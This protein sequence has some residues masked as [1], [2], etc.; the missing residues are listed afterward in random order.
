MH[1]WAKKLS[2]LKHST[3][4]SLFARDPEKKICFRC[5]AVRAKAHTNSACNGMLRCILHCIPSNSVRLRSCKNL[6]I[7]IPFYAIIIYRKFFTTTSMSFAFTAHAGTRRTGASNKKWERASG[8]Y[9]AKIRIFSSL[10]L[11]TASGEIAF[12]CFKW[13][14]AAKQ[15]QPT[16]MHSVGRIPSIHVALRM[17]IH[18]LMH[19]LCVDGKIVKIPFGLACERRENEWNYFSSLCIGA[20]LALFPSFLLFLFCVFFRFRL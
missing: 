2:Q 17:K 12:Q 10:T 4:H 6:R 20:V 8:E 5:D 13:R 9:S 14:R 11:G 19:F 18:I 1:V 15:R 16:H 3:K 7:K